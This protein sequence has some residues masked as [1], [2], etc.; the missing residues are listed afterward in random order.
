MERLAVS[1]DR[2][3]ITTLLQGLEPYMEQEFV[4]KAAIES[5]GNLW[6][7]IY[8]ALEQSGIDVSLANPLKTKAIA[9]AR[10][11]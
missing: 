8:E 6:I 10:I 1:N 2:N 5:T 7:N 4:I 11:K 9:E 3:G